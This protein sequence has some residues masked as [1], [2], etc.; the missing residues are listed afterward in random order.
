[1]TEAD[2]WALQAFE[3]ELERLAYL[4]ARRSELAA[5]HQRTVDDMPVRVEY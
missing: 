2:R 1:M 3:F 5:R 4:A